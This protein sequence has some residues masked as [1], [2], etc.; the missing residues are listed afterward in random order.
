MEMKR[1]IVTTGITGAMLM[2][3]GC[4]SSDQTRNEGVAMVRGSTSHPATLLFTCDDGKSYE[5]RSRAY[6]GSAHHFSISLPRDA[7]CRLWIKREG[8]TFRHV[9]FKDYRGNLSPLVYLKDPRID[10]GEI[11]VGQ[12]DSLVM[13]VNDDVMLVASK[14]TTPGKTPSTQQSVYLGKMDRTRQSTRRHERI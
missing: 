10:L 7:I 13:N 1:W 3:A 8:S 14:E 4:T 9:T 11:S 5:T 2:T 12:R 6:G